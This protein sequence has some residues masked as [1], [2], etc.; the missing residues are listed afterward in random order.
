MW[1]LTE[2]TDDKVPP[3][4]TVRYELFGSLAL[5]VDAVRGVVSWGIRLLPDAFLDVFTEGTS[6]S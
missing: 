6:C 5:D 1:S 4:G 2:R 3:G